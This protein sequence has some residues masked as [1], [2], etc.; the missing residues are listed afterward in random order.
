MNPKNGEI[1][2]ACSYPLPDFSGK[3][4][5]DPDSLNLKLVS[6]SYEPG[7]VFKVVTTAIGMENT[8]LGLIPRLTFLSPLM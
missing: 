1:Y 2:A 8:L 5:L 6:N 3:T 4:D 7:S